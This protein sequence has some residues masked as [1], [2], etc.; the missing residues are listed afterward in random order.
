MSAAQLS[1]KNLRGFSSFHG[2]ILLGPYSAYHPVVQVT[3][4]QHSGYIKLNSV[5]LSGIHLYCGSLEMS[6]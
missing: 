6:P 3:H 5:F 2:S 1:D 4:P